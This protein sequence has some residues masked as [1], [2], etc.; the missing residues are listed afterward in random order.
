MSYY[1]FDAHTG[2]S[3]SDTTVSDIQIVYNSTFMETQRYSAIS[4]LS[5]FSIYPRFYIAEIPAT[6]IATTENFFR[7]LTDVKY[8]STVVQVLFSL[9]LNKETTL[10]VL[11]CIHVRTRG[12]CSNYR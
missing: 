5:S 4:I 8:N 12:V 1:G 11:K 9:L 7:K 3:L 2:R 10:F 6:T